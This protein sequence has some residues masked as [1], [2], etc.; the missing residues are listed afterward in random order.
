[1]HE[2]NGVYGD[3]VRDSAFLASASVGLYFSGRTGV[4]PASFPLRF[5]SPDDVD[6]ALE[7]R[8]IVW[9]NEA[10]PLVFDQELAALLRIRK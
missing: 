4:G 1:M 5:D 6:F 8:N 10:K 7:R 3:A 2:C 9:G